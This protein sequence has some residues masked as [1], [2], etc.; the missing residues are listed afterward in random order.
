MSTSNKYLNFQ[1]NLRRIRTLKSQ[2]Q[3]NITSSCGKDRP[4]GENVPE[5][6][7]LKPGNKESPVCGGTSEILPNER[8]KATFEINELYEYLCG[9]KE[10]VKRRKF[11]ESVVTKDYHKY[12]DS[13]NNTRSELLAESVGEFVKIHK[14]FKDFKPTRADISTMAEISITYG[15][16]SNSHGIFMQTILG[17]GSDEQV[18]FWVPKILNFEITGAYAQT[19]LGHGS[20]IRS[21]RTIAEYDKETD[22]FV[23]NTPS[24]RSIK[25]W[26]GALGKAA[27]HCSLYAQ[28][29]VDNKEYGLAVFMMQL[30]DENH[31]PLKGIRLGDLGTKIGDNSNDTGFMI[32]NNVRIPRE[33][34][35]SKYKKVTREGKYE[36]VKETDPKVHY[37]TMIQ[38]RANLCNSAASR[39]AQAATIAVRYSCVRTQGFE[40][41]KPGVSYLTKEH[42][43]IDHQIQRYRLLKQV[44]T[45]YALKFTARWIIEQQATI[46]GEELG[47]IKNTDLFK[48]LA[49]NTAGLKSL[50]SIIAT[51]A[52]EDLRKTCGGNGYLLHSGIA[53]LCCHYLW[54]PTGE[55]D[56]IILG[57]FM[58][59]HITSTINNILKGIQVK[60]DLDYLNILRSDYNNIENLKP[61]RVKSSKDLLDLDYLLS[62][63]RYRSID[64]NYAAAMRLNKLVREKVKY[65]VAWDKCSL[66]LY[67][68][69]HAHV[70]YLIFRNF[71]DK[72][73]WMANPAIKKVLAQLAVL[74]ACSN[75]A[76]SNWSDVFNEDEICFAQNIIENTL[77]EIRPNA[78]ALVD[79]FGY[80][81]GVL[82]SSIGRYDGNVYEALFD[83]AQRSTLNQTDPFDGYKYLEPHLNKKL[84]KHGNKS[85]KG[86]KF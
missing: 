63:Y 60:G 6:L 75:F 53:D 10:A 15:S 22:E 56:M 16:L 41:T 39:V 4:T 49:A 30:R 61:H 1:S 42:Q 43:I 86:V 26:P 79:A 14:K 65:E 21:L 58:A 18:R 84:L 71:V 44:A 85:L 7:V 45:A 9:G 32:L 20:N 78:V 80:P 66:E 3:A 81:D 48:E 37:T 59:R 31:L 33:S 8:K 82:K 23:L 34:M 13:Y 54:Q 47:V 24:L 57:L 46:E 51:E 27:T 50:M 40:D 5:Y 36:E 28:L 55:G 68:A 69:S 2:L 19:E 74:F 25:W 17:Q 73:N 77:P 35:L 29:V 70:Y 52:C 83:A 62:I 11:I 76:D 72:I 38:M 12:H 67:S 64:K